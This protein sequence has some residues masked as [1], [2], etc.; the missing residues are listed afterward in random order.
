MLKNIAIYPGTF[1]PITHGH[2]DII[3]RAS[4]LYTHLIVGVAQ[5]ARKT[6]A[7]PF[8][9]RLQLVEI[10]SADFATVTVLPLEG[11]LI[12]FARHHQAKVI[13]RSFRAVSDFDY[14]LQLAA[15]NQQMAP[16]IETLFL[17]PAPE[18]AFISATM[19]RE[20]MSLGGDIS[21]FVPEKVAEALKKL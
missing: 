18:Y 3:T 14:E 9:T 13:L 12:E 8:A 1:D 11:L 5:S 10:V 19:I 2:L 16:E 20:I 21:A 15:M 4:K 17:A 6:P 7:L